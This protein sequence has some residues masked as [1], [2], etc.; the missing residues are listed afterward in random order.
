VTHF[1]NQLDYFEGLYLGAGITSSIAVARARGAVVGQMLGFASHET[2]NDYHDAAVAFLQ[3][4][5]NGTT[6]Y[7]IDLIGVYG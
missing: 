7:G 5:S 3:D 2:G 4:A 1:Q 6:N